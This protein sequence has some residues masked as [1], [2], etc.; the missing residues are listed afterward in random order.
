MLK[1]LFILFF[2]ASLCAAD[3]IKK[4]E[5]S[6]SNNSYMK[7]IGIC[8]TAVVVY[9]IIPKLLEG[10]GNG[11]RLGTLAGAAVGAYG[12]TQLFAIGADIDE[13]LFPSEA[14]KAETA[15]A[16]KQYEMLSS[17]RV[18]RSCLMK[19]SAKPRNVAGIPTECESFACAYATAAGKPALDEMTKTFNDTYKN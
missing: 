12:L 10:S 19:N 3:N 13:A 15:A 7:S 16:H 14:K 18:L 1:Q 5:L 6:R 11:K 9:A 8:L 2:S 4:P 17:K